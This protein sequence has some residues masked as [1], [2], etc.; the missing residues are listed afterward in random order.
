MGSEPTRF[1]LFVNLE[2]LTSH[3]PC[4]AS[5]P[6]TARALESASDA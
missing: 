3:P 2:R 5:S 4:S 1:P 6:A